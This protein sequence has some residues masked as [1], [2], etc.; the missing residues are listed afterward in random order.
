[1]RSI[2]FGNVDER[3]LPPPEHRAELTFGHP[4]LHYAWSRAVL[5]AGEELLDRTIERVGVDQVAYVDLNGDEPEEWTYGRLRGEV[6]RLAHGLRTLGI[7]PGERVLTRFSDRPQA[8]VVQLAL[9]KVG[10]I[11]VPSATVEA[12]REIAYMANDTESVAIICETDS[13]VEVEQAVP[14]CPTA[15]SS[16]ASLLSRPASPTRSRPIPPR[17]SMPPASTTRAAPP[18]GPRAACTPTPPSSRSPTSTTRRA[19]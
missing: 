4:M 10:A 14:G 3:F 12:A 6:D 19:A 16:T 17:R 11:I 1:M 8:A 18:A 2:M 7:R 9:W 5:N 15:P 13:A